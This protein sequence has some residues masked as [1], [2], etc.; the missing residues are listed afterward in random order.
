MYCVSIKFF[1]IVHNN[2]CAS[3][4]TVLGM[5]VV[6]RGRLWR[7][8]IW[9]VVRDRDLSACFSTYEVFSKLCSTHHQHL[10]S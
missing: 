9:N 8:F 5:D 10:V 4:G 3:T 7:C 2:Y 1:N 6:V